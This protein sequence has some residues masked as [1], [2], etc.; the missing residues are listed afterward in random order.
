MSGPCFCHPQQPHPHHQQ[1]HQ[2]KP[3]RVFSQQKNDG[4][5]ER[6]RTTNK[7]T[8]RGSHMV[9]NHEEQYWLKNVSLLIVECDHY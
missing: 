7:P 2:E 3:G 1:L 9:K 6:E 8:N 4:G 5:I